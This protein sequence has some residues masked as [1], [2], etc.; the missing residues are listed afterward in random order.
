MNCTGGSRLSWL[1]AIDGLDCSGKE[2]FAKMLYKFI[3]TNIKSTN[4]DKRS[5]PDKR[6]IK[7]HLLSFPDYTNETGKKLQEMLKLPINQRNQDELTRLF[8]ENRKEVLDNLELAPYNIIIF[9]RFITS[10]I[11]YGMLPHMINSS[12][13]RTH[14]T[15]MAFYK[16]L[17]EAANDLENLDMWSLDRAVIFSR[18][19]SKASARKHDELLAKKENRDSNETPNI[20]ARL[21]KIID[22][23]LTEEVIEEIC[24]QQ[25]NDVDTSDIATRLCLDEQFRTNIKIGKTFNK[26]RCMQLIGDIF[27]LIKLYLECFGAGEDDDK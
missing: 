26:T 7:V 5:N 27:P 11:I 8:R 10:N 13:I 4:P 17:K 12:M 6:N 25:H 2:T 1:I 15:D 23:Y 9:D 19:G 20:Q 14:T 21:S 18:F 16:L 22:M 3:N 24:I